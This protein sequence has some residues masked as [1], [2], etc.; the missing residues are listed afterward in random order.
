MT[1]NLLAAELDRLLS[2][3]VDACVERERT[4]FDRL[5][6]PFSKSIVLFGCGNL[7]R[8]AL[9]CLTRDNIAPL[10]FTDNN[11]SLWGTTINGVS[12]ISPEEAAKRFGQNAAFVVTVRSHEGKHRFAETKRKLSNLQCKRVISFVPL[13]WKYAEALLPNYY[14]DLPHKILEHKQD[15]RA[16]FDLWADDLSRTTYLTQLKWR[17]L[18]I[19]DELPL[20]TFQRQYFPSELFTLLRDEVFT[21]CGAF[22]GDTI[23]DF[24]SNCRNNFK[25]IISIEPDPLNVKRLEEYVHALPVEVSQNIRLVRAAIGKMESIVKFSR[26]GTA[27]SSISELGDYDVEVLT[28]DDILDG[29][30]PTYIKMDVEGAEEDALMGGRTTIARHSPMLSVCVYHLYDH[31]WKIPLLIEKISMGNSFFLRAHQDEGWELVCYAI[32]KKRLTTVQ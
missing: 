5:V 13:L 14:L 7:G 18:D 1:Q 26:T 31:L 10:A 6:A 2:E 4:A 28:L 30:Q 8:E 3:D 19:Y 25:K 32:S 23:K 21:D 17:M 27:A 20:R 15:V 29:I 12:V 22:D 24:L 11:P 9:A 16:A